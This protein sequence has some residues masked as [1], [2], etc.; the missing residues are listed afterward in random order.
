MDQHLHWKCY[1]TP[2]YITEIALQNSEASLDYL[3]NGAETRNYPYGKEWNWIS[4]SHYIEQSIPD[5][6]GI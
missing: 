3:I 5:G 1:I 4:T 6:L 2:E